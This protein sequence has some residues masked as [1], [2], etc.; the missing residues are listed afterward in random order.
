[1]AANDKI[2]LKA[3]TEKRDTLSDKAANMRVKVA[4]LKVDIDHTKRDIQSRDEQIER[5]TDQLMSQLQKIK[6]IDDEKARLLR[7]LAKSQE[8]R[9]NINPKDK[10]Q[11]LMLAVQRQNSSAEG[12]G[13]A[14]SGESAI[15]NDLAEMARTSQ[16]LM[17]RVRA[18]GSGR[19]NSTGGGGGGN[20][21]GGSGPGG[22][23]SGG[24]ELNRVKVWYNK[25]SCTFKVTELHTFRDLLDEVI[26]YW[27]LEPSKNVLVNAQNFIWPLNASVREVIGA[28]PDGKDDPSAIIK[29]WN[30]D[31]RDTVTFD[32]WILHEDKLQKD[33]EESEQHRKLQSAVLDNNDESGRGGFKMEMDDDT[34][35]SSGGS[36]S[37]TGGTAAGGAFSPTTFEQGMDVAKMSDQQERKEQKSEHMKVSGMGTVNLCK[38][39]DLFIFL[40]FI[41]LFGNTL[42]MRRSVWR[43]GLVR[44]GMVDVL[45]SQSNVPVSLARSQVLYQGLEVGTQSVLPLQNGGKSSTQML[46]FAQINSGSQIWQWLEGPFRSV[47][48]GMVNGTAYIGL[49]QASS[50]TNEQKNLTGISFLQHNVMVGVPRITQWRV[51]ESELDTNCVKPER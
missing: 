42:F 20:G 1:M 44:N 39:V 7:L 10:L 43:A 15:M 24:G 13:G 37:K 18:V 46:D 45:F 14:G 22:K 11:A 38:Y 25:T 31:Q 40:L 19:G 48:T 12:A 9:G 28:L 51:E 21:S 35:A 26:Q 6:A 32:Q 5:K 2:K 29:V 34:G 50:S 47:A 49:N 4:E 8:Q 3:L 33:R 27:S 41:T 30:R 36:G 17:T 23:A 16:R